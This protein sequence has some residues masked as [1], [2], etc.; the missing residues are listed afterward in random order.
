[1]NKEICFNCGKTKEDY[2]SAYCDKCWEEEQK[3][4]NT[5]KLIIRNKDND[6]SIELDFD[7]LDFGFGIGD[8]F[9]NGNY[10]GSQIGFCWNEELGQEYVDHIYMTLYVGNEE[11]SDLYNLNTTLK[12]LD[13]SKPLEI[14]LSNMDYAI[15]TMWYEETHWVGFHYYTDEEIAEREKL[16]DSVIITLDKSLLNNQDIDFFHYGYSYELGVCKYGSIWCCSRG[17]LKCEYTDG[18]ISTRNYDDIIRYYVRN[19]DE[20]YKAVESGKLYFMLGN[21]F[22]IE[23][24]DNEGNYVDNIYDDTFGSIGECI[25]TLLHDLQNDEKFIENFLEI[26]QI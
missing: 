17:E 8:Y 16:K 7:S 20:Y 24:I 1:M 26:T 18:D 15:F 11:E 2:E 14:V 12:N 3:R 6:K 22:E 25:D 9:Y 19:N 4:L 10:T 23:F 21:W 13:L 5:K